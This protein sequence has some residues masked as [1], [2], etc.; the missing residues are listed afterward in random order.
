VRPVIG[1]AA[2]STPL[3]EPPCAFNGA[4]SHPEML[5]A[6]SNISELKYVR[7]AGPAL[8]RMSATKRP[9]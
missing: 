4:A 9:C 2:L 6:E 3:L 5:L 7:A 1:A 8:S